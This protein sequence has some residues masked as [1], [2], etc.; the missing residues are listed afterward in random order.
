MTISRIRA[1]PSGVDPYGD[2]IPGTEQATE[3]V[4][5][6]VA[7]RMSND[8]NDAGRTGVIV[9]L[10][11]FVPFA[12]DIVHTDHFDVDGIRYRVDGEPGNWRNPFTDWKAGATVALVRAEG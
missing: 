5:A 7:P 10:T 9:G 1:M 12:T 11:L 6:F 8:I 2:P 4:G 3:I